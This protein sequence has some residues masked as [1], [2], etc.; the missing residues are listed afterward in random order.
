[1]QFDAEVFVLTM[2]HMVIL[3]VTTMARRMLPS[4]SA[5]NV[6]E[7]CSA[8]A[9][10]YEKGF[11]RYATSE[12]DWGTVEKPNKNL[13][14]LLKVR[15]ESSTPAMCHKLHVICHMLLLYQQYA[16]C[17]ILALGTDILT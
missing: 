14:N 17:G 8:W 5:T 16:V 10:C 6:N 9:Q 13:V 12:D 2:C 7:V 11:W 1:M 3:L 4:R 15:S